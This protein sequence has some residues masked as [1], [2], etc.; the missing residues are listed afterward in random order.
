VE[1]Q[2]LLEEFK[3]IRLEAA[4]EEGSSGNLADT[5]ARIKELLKQLDTKD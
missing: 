4:L 1:I 2:T 3:A 5:L